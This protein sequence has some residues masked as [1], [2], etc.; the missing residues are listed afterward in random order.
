MGVQQRRVFKEL[1][2]PI[3]EREL[4]FVLGK[5]K[6]SKSTSNQIPVE[7]F[8]ACRKGSV[9]FGHLV[10]LVG[11]V[12]ESGWLSSGLWRTLTR[13]RCRLLRSRRRCAVYARRCWRSTSPSATRAGLVA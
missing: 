4:H 12:F 7:P 9:A 6:S 11:D 3:S 8:R 5:A 2:N 13:S 1:N 10:Q